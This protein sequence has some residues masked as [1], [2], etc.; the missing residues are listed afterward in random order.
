[1]WTLA[2]GDVSLQAP[3]RTRLQGR[4]AEIPGI[5]RRCLGC[6]DLRRDSREG[7]F[8]F[9]AIVGMIGER[10]SHDEQ[11][12]LIHSHLRVVILL[13]ARIR[14]IFHNARLR[15]GIVVLV[16]IARSWHWRGRRPATRATSR[17]ARSLC[18]LR[19]LGLIFS[20]LACRTP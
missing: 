11:T 8:G 16:S 4:G 12:P 13:E 10:P 14:R 7:G 5:Q 2:R 6:A 19:Q 3:L 18:A 1:M 15:V 17:G 20:L 9:L